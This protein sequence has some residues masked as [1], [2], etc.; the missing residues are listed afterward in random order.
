MFPWPRFLTPSR[1]MLGAALLCLPAAGAPAPASTAEILHDL[2]S[3]R[4]MGSVLYIAAHPDDENNRLLAYLARGR[5]YRTAY[6][7]L[8][9]GDGGQDLL[10]P[11]LGDELGVIRTQELL[12]ARRI[13]GGRQFFTRAR[14]FGFS[15]DYADTLRRWNRTEV[16][17]DIVRVIREFQPDVLITRFSPIPG[18]THGHHTASAVLAIE[19]FKAAGDPHAFPDQLGALAPWQPKRILWNCGF[20]PM[21]PHRGPVLHLNDGGYDP[22]LGESFGEI[23]AQS[24]SMHKS[25]G[26]GS[27]GTRG[28]ADESFVLL[29][30]AVAT[31]DIFDGVDTSWDRIAGGAEIGR[32]ADQVLARFKPLNPSAS[33]PELLWIRA[34]LAT[35]PTSPLIAAKRRL[36]DR[37]IQSCL[38][39]Y[40]ETTIASAEVVPGETLHLRETAIVRG[41]Y[42]VR[43]I[44]TRYPTTGGGAGGPMSL[45]FDR[46]AT[47]RS[48]ATLPPGT[49]LTEP[50]WLREDHTPNM[51]RV[52][53]PSLIGRPEAPPA[54]PVEQVFAVGDQTLIVADQP[55]EV[56]RDPLRG[57]IRKRLQVI[58]PVT[59]GFGNDLELFAPG[60]TRTVVATV[61]AARPVAAGMLRLAAPAGWTVSPAE[62]AFHFGAAGQSGA[63]VFSI[64]APADTRTAEVTATARIG[65]HTYRTG[66][67]DISF[68]HIPEQLL[69][70]PARLK[71][72]CLNVAIRGRRVGYLSG[73]GDEVA[74]GME[75]LGYAVKTLSGA[76]LTPEG[77][78]GLHAV[79]LGVRAFNTR[80]DLAPRLPA[81]F[82][83]IKAG[84]TVVAL[85]D[86][87]NGLKRIR[88]APY[89]L[90]LSE[91][92]VTNEK[93]AMTLLAPDHPALATPNRIGP[94]DFDGWVQERGSYFAGKWDSHFVPLVACHDAGEAP[95]EGGLLVARYGHGYYVYTG[96][97]F[98]RQLPAGVPGAYR[99]FANLLSL[100]R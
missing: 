2:L 69:Q 93:A 20:G 96:L 75:R 91:L 52:D 39:L 19:A 88:L 21:L 35:L 87:P 57:E 70:P 37:V 100:G 65:D 62:Q 55:V 3:F 94:A 76:D 68:P 89:P 64:T 26:M 60:S 66:R 34:R 92:R 63:F 29:D 81:L 82:A 48:D 30:G 25:Q 27:V 72:V 67:E 8:T 41:H 36:L 74:A 49:P 59:L 95:L 73:A 10:G 1:A 80:T 18:H 31:R 11:E 54:F 33:V 56:I 5:N 86:R 13:D 84:G 40:V 6:L 38:G 28:A 9:R 85:Y 17:S 83:Y 44:A 99:L 90:R 50:Y 14:D 97:A 61:T 58:P 98:F 51:Y 42:P 77:L 24:R 7:S 47:R 22:L 15:K 32:M 79:V 53:D 45:S 16:L 23:A 4:E 78:K 43:W 71:A 46:A 12:G